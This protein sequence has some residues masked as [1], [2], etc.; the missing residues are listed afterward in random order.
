MLM[1]S[2]RYVQGHGGYRHAS[3]VRQ[4][5]EERGEIRRQRR[6]VQNEH[7]P[8]EPYSHDAYISTAKR[9]NS[10]TGTIHAGVSKNHRRTDAQSRSPHTRATLVK[11]FLRIHEDKKAKQSVT[12]IELLAS[13]RRVEELRLISV[14]DEGK[15]VLREQETACLTPICLSKTSSVDQVGIE[16]IVAS[17][18]SH[19]TPLGVE[20]EILVLA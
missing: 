18:I 13:K 16:V 14:E 12:L 4:D 7:V 1:P 19:D 11:E 5:Q 3:N 20:R 15:T 17:P 9:S 8:F 6:H 10:W 2:G